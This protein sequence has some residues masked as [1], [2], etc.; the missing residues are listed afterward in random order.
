[1]QDLLI[2][3]IDALVALVPSD[4]EPAGRVP[5]LELAADRAEDAGQRSTASI[6]AGD[7][8]VLL[9]RG[10]DLDLLQFGGEERGRYFL[11]A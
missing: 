8:Q 3:E 10:P 7:L 1:M 5:D 6:M 4:L 11:R 9:D 2:G